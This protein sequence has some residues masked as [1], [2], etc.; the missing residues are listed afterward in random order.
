MAVYTEVTDN[1]V[2]RL[3]A[4]YD[5][6]GA[7][8]LKGIAEGVENSNFLLTVDGGT[9]YILTLYEKRVNVDD[10][11]FFLGLMEHLAGRGVTCP[12][13]VHDKD[14]NLLQTVADRKAAIIT[15]LTGRWPKEIT[16]GHCFAVGAEMARLH[17]AGEGFA[18]TRQNA[19]ST[20]GWKE[21]MDAVR[22]EADRYETGLS[23]E[24]DAA[25]H[26][27]V[28]AW[29]TD[30]PVGVIH[31]DL[32]PDNVFFHQG[33]LSGIIDFYFACNDML[34]YDLAIGIN[35]WC[36]DEDGGFRNDCAA[37]MIAGYQSVRPLEAAEEEAFATL[38][39]GAAIRFLLT[40]LYDWLNQVPG[41][42][43]KVKDPGDYIRRLRFHLKADGFNT[44]ATERD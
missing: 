40:R 32:F 24:L 37:A 14:G 21:L 10:L 41:A 38:C 11:P 31:A 17:I 6:G 34:A 13:P 25:M 5:I 35:A 30:L 12:L 43:V 9:N 7:E 2:D 36:F 28:P 18:L 20:D 27:I 4:Q 26:A 19:L 1:D 8:A 44:Y 16:T 42:L 39:Q 33:A 15:F 3:L 29:P 22:A 23:A